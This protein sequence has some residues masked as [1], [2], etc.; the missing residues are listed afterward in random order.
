MA[1][2]ATLDGWCRNLPAGTMFAALT[3]QK[4]RRRDTVA[5]QIKHA[6]PSQ[7][8][9]LLFLPTYLLTAEGDVKND[10]MLFACCNKNVLQDY[11]IAS[12]MELL[13][14][15]WACLVNTVVPVN[16]RTQV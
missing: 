16:V 5:N 1:R 9:F 11:C 13:K 15:S 12:D 4:R 10:G 6:I 3:N 7:V 2:C 8:V 14:N